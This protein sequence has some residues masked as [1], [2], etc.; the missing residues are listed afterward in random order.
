MR[1][2][3]NRGARRGNLDARLMVDPAYRADPFPYYEQ[4]RETYP[5]VKGGL[6][7]PVPT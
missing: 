5:L 7:W 4:L 3:L 2:A 6:A 1:L